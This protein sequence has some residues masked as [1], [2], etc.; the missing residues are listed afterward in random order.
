MRSVRSQTASSSGRR[1][2]KDGAAYASN[3]ALAVTYGES[4]TNWTAS[5]PSALQSPRRPSRTSS[6]AAEGTAVGTS[7]GATST[8]LL[9]VMVSAWC[10]SCKVK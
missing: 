2:A 3:S 9:A 8:M 5:S 4:K 1:A 10:G 6:H 7:T